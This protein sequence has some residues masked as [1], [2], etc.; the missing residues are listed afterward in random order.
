[1]TKRN[2]PPIHGGKPTAQRHADRLARNA[3][4]KA[5]YHESKSRWLDQTDGKFTTPHR[6]EK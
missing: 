1:M 5:K 4:A 2:L 3:S 6:K